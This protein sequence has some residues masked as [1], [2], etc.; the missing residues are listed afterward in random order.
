VGLST[1]SIHE[2]DLKNDDDDIE[3]SLDSKDNLDV[4][5]TD[6]DEDYTPRTPKK[7]KK[8]VKFDV[9]EV[10]GAAPVPP[11]SPD[12]YGHTHKTDGRNETGPGQLFRQPCYASFL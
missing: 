2:N 8:K 9:K 10:P 6:D 1:R 3:L 11:P 7:L 12:T 5:D 4:S